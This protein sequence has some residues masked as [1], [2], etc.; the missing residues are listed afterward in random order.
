MN[1]N[2]IIFTLLV[3]VFVGTGLA[4][5]CGGGGGGSSGL[6]VAVGQNAILVSTDG[7]TWSEADS[8][9]AFSNGLRDVAY[10]GNGLWVTVGASAGRVM[11]ISTDGRNW[12]NPTS[13]AT[14]MDLFSVAHGNGVWVAGG[15]EII[16]STD[17]DTWSLAS[18]VPGD[19]GTA[20]GLG[21]GE[22]TYVAVGGGTEQVIHSTDA[23][24]WAVAASTNTIYSLYSI[25]Y[26]DSL[27]VATG[28]D[29]RIMNSAD[30]DYWNPANDV[31]YVTDS[32][33]SAIFA[34]GKWIAV[35][36]Y[37]FIFSS[38]DGDNWSTVMSAIPGLN[39]FTDIAYGNKTWVAVGYSS[40]GTYEAVIYNSNDG[41]NW[42]QAGTL[43]AGITQLWGVAFGP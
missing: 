22:G 34:D 18:S 14:N 36:E 12:V 23:D 37:G 27:W 10:D 41:L 1:R 24:T 39:R 29:N 17:G 19:F 8:K 31:P 4:L 9:P 26:G 15:M 13:T 7:D 3:A 21:F 40:I 11:H 28:G 20:Y 33:E 38:S 35:G 42:D 16:Y 32:V 43:P 25:A 30:G 6:F 2:G 5:S